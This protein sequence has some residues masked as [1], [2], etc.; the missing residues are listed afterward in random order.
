MCIRDRNIG[1]TKRFVRG[2]EINRETLA[3]EVIEKVGPGGHFLAETHT[4]N[5]F[6]HE[7]WRP[8]LMARGDRET[9]IQDGSKD[10][11]AVIQE[12]LA[13]IIENHAVPSL[14]GDIID[15]FSKIKAKGDKL[16]T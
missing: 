7:F 14:S 3:R 12:K 2:I 4:L 5:H 16:L 10:M 13:H 11:Q 1:M 8:G 6:K 9:W 15:S